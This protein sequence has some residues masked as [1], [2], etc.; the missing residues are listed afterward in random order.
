MQCRELLVRR[1]EEYQDISVQLVINI[2]LFLRCFICATVDSL[3][4]IFNRRQ[5]GNIIVSKMDFRPIKF[6]CIGTIINDKNL[7]F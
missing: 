2:L 7:I 4:S 6:H 5:T 3:G 1:I